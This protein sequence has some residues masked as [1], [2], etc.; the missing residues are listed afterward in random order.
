MKVVVGLD[1]SPLGE[2]ALFAG[3][4]Q[5]RGGELHVVTVVGGYDPMKRLEYAAEGQRLSLTAEERAQQE[6]IAELLGK[7][8]AETELVR[9]VLV[10]PAAEE[11][12]RVARSADADLIVVGTHGR[13]GVKRLVLGSVAERL[14]R[15]ASCPV[16]VIREKSWGSAADQIPGAGRT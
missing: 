14:V 4:E 3:L 16:L 8:A 1:D 5:A 10:G 9:H 15:E 12:A 13:R 6:R 7:R 2:A 11:I